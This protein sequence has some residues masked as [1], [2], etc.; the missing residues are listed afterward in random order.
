ML[1]E[2]LVSPFY[3]YYS[4]WIGAV[5]LVRPFMLRRQSSTRAT[6]CKFGRFL[7]LNRLTLWFSFLLVQC[8]LSTVFSAFQ[9]VNCSVQFVPRSGFSP[10]RN[11]GRRWCRQQLVNN[12]QHW[13]SVSQYCFKVETEEKEKKT[14]LFRRKMFISLLQ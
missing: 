13:V 8:V 3:T 12:I 7:P 11:P 14:K 4:H 5:T 6:R 10:K 2:G 1:S 9:L